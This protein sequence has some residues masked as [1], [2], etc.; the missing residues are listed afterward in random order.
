MIKIEIL[1]E[2][3]AGDLDDINRMLPSLTELYDGRTVNEQAIRKAIASPLHEQFVARDESG[4]IV[5]MANL[6]EVI[7]IYYGSIAYLE[8]LF[9]AADVAQRGIG[10]A[11]WEEMLTWC[12]QRGIKRMEFTCRPERVAAHNFYL[13]HGCKVRNTDAFRLDI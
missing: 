7:S 6:T 12:R 8:E 1:K 4:R 3:S 9:V 10:S 5:G 2:L 13:K 11:I